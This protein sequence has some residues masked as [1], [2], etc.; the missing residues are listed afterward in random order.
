MTFEQF[1][2]ALVT[3]LV[4]IEPVAIVPLFLAVTAG[5]S[6]EQRRQTALRA[7]I[8]AF[9][10]LAGVALVGDWVLAKLGITLPAFRIAGGLL[11]FWIAFEMVFQLRAQR[12]SSTA[13]AAI[14]IDHVKNVAP[15]RWRSRCSRVPAPSPRRCS[16]PVRRGATRS[17]SARSSASS[18][19]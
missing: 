11:L 16:S 3:L 7:S 19:S 10:I 13:K 4:I 18:P 6:P 9:A 1:T 14:E 5:F 17:G 12:K 8:I 2:N 15:S